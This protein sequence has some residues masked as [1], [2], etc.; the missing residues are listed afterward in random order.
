MTRRDPKDAAKALGLV[1]RYAALAKPASR[2]AGR[3][4]PCEDP[5]LPD[6]TPA[7]Y[8]GGVCGYELSRTTCYDRARDSLRELQL[9]V[10]DI[11]GTPE[12]IELM[13]EDEW[14]AGCRE[15]EQTWHEH[16]AAVRERGTVKRK[17]CA[18]ARRIGA[19]K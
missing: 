7:P 18:L 15:N 8:D 17:M 4:V 10:A 6:G 12:W 13:R 2:P 19:S 9:G 5:R 11:V 14:C 1:L 3:M 16:R